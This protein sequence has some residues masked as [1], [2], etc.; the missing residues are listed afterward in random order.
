MSNALIESIINGILMGGLYGFMAVGL[1]LIFG[2]VKVI[3]FAH[4]SFIM[5][6]MFIGYWL[7]VLLGMDPYLSLLIIVPLLFVVGYFVQG[8]LIKPVLIAEAGE[9]EPIGILVLTAGL[10][11]FLDNLALVL[12]GPNFRTVTTRY[13]G[14]TFELGN[15]LISTPRLY[16]FLISLVTMAALF[17]FLKKTRIGKAIRATG[18]DRSIAG[19]MGVDIYRIYN[20]A[21]G[22][23]IALTGVTG[24]LLTPFYP[25]YPTV[26]FV[27]DIRAFMIVVLGGLGSIQGAL[28]AGLII[29]LIES[30]GAQFM[31]TSWTAGLI[32]LIFLLV[33]YFKP[34]GMFGF[35]GE[36]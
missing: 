9:R 28:L 15:V 6:G 27:F 5:V 17:L 36:W 31:E 19:L 14:V 29:G 12:F 25:V 16:A 13:T 18:Q 26:G 33:L 2:I 4:G 23:G 7:C 20:I 8:V 32:F 24:A 21:F 11:L 1:T 30:V 10:W 3:N 34:E 35:K 22:L